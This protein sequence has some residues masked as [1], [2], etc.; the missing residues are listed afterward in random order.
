MLTV[1][2]ATLSD[3]EAIARI[4]NQGIQGGQSTFETRPRT[5]DDVKRWFDGHPIVVAELN[6]AVVGFA[7]TSVYRPREC[8][9][10]I[11][12][13]SVYVDAGHRR[14]GV[15]RAAMQALMNEA[16]KSGFW[17]LVSRVFPENTASLALLD[18]LGFRR[19]GAYLRHGKLNGRWRDTVIVEKLL[20]QNESES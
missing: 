7:A 4:Y 10:G 19:V 9:A 11:A 14:A 6:G 2:S 13:F 8:Y 3:A 18:S 17:K 5:A 16:A 1:R 20:N 15:A 12:E